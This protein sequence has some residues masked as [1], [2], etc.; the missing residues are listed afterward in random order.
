MPSGREQVIHEVVELAVGALAS[1]DAVS[2][3][4]KMDSSQSQGFRFKKVK[5][6]ISYKDKTT[7]EG[8]ILFGAAMGGDAS[9]IEEALEADPQG[10][11]DNPAGERSNRKVWPIAMIPAASETDGRNA[12]LMREVY[13]PFKEKREGDG[14]LF[15]AYNMDTATLTTGALITAW[16]T[17]FGTWLRD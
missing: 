12:K 16:F 17:Y 9:E 1:L 14:I 10:T 4:S 5:G 6:A 8:P 3:A 11:N 2:A 13:W 15:W 7:L